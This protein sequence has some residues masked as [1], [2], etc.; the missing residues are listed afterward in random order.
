MFV[1]IVITFCNF[2]EIEGNKQYS[3]VRCSPQCIRNVIGEMT[4]Q[5]KQRVTDLGFGQLLEMAM[6]GNSDRVLG[7]FLTSRVKENPLRIDVGSEPLLITPD[8]VHRVLGI[9]MG[10]KSLP[11]WT[12]KQ[13][14]EARYE[15]RKICDKKGLKQK[16]EAMKKDYDKL[17][18]TKVPRWFIE[19]AANAHK[20]EID[21]W[22][23]QAFFILLF[24][25][26]LFPTSSDK[27][28]G[29]NYLMA[30]DLTLIPNIN[31]CNEVVEDIKM[32]SRVWNKSISKAKNTPTIQ[33]CMTFLVVSSAILI[34][35]SAI[36][37]FIHSAILSSFQLSSCIKLL[38]ITD[39]ILSQQFCFTHINQSC[40]LIC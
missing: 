22:A 4:P 20:R 21:D 10:E 5:M 38:M 9:P 33:G 37:M 14:Q 8:A 2:Q 24:N 12:P 15:L 17:K 26:F 1:T 25:S 31:W 35:L 11:S 34:F 39:A 27:I 13:V 32:K 40:L 18:F 19:D 28:V 16:Y 23:V 30:K 7:M 6:E 36:Y 3:T 29:E